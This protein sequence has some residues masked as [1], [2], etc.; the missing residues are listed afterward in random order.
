[1]EEKAAF[2]RLH[3]QQGT[4]RQKRA[5]MCALQSLNYQLSHK[6]WMGAARLTQQRREPLCISDHLSVFG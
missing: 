3:R 2:R 1:M 5:W 4:A 6:N